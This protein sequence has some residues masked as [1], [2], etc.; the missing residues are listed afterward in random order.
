ML[1]DVT[2]SSRING[3][4]IIPCGRQRQENKTH[5]QRR[6]KFDAEGMLSIEKWGVDE[7]YGGGEKAEGKTA[8]EDTEES[9]QLGETCYWELFDLERGGIGDV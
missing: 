7:S 6:V 1:R 9:E 3:T 2:T 4:I 8:K 5:S